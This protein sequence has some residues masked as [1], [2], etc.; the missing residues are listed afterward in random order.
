MQERVNAQWP[1]FQVKPLEERLLPKEC[2]L[3]LGRT[4]RTASVKPPMTL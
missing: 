2:R 1:S 3:A 4:N